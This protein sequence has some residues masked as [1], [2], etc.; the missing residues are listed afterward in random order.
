MSSNTFISL[1]KTIGASVSDW[2]ALGDSHSCTVTVT[3]ED[4]A[5]LSVVLFAEIPFDIAQRGQEDNDES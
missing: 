5:S 3:H 1:H 4:G 2:R